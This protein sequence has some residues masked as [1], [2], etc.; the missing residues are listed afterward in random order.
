MTITTADLQRF[1]DKDSKKPEFRELYERHDYLTA[2]SKHTD[3]RVRKDP[4]WSIGRGDEWESHGELQLSFLRSEGLLPTDSLLD[5][6]CGC[7]RA[8]RKFVPYLDAGNYVGVD[9]SG[10]ALDYAR[11]LAAREGWANKSPEFYINGH[12]DLVREFDF[13]WAH[14][15]FTHLPPDQVDRMIGNAARIM[16][17][18]FLFTYKRERQPIRTGLKQ[19]KY[20]PRF[21]R[22]AAERHGL[23]FE[24]LDVVWPA[25][26]R[27]I[28]LTKA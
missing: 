16:R 12:L 11:K 7:G 2:Y 5:I 10:E 20:P 22:N 17:G 28:R 14:S 13:L 21:F 4:H 24:E 6:G 8:A 9:I 25:S 19:F 15:V 26:Q 3:L 1:T 27:T 23:H 18:S